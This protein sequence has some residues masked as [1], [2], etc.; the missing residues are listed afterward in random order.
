MTITHVMGN[1]SCGDIAA[2]A[3][4]DAGAAV[5]HA[6]KEPCHRAGAGYTQRSLDKT[7]PHYLSLEKGRHLYLNLIDPPLPLFQRESFARFFDFVDRHIAA[8]PVLIHCNKGES[9]APSLA[10]LYMAKRGHLTDESYDAA[11][12]SFAEKFPY[13]PGQGIVTFLSENWR[14]L[15]LRAYSCAESSSTSPSSGA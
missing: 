3:N 15:G 12:A 1:L 7:H 11:R 14:A 2:C 13:K 8:R 10:L 6:C 4:A 5:V 9:R